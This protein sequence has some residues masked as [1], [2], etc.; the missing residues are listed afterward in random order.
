MDILNLVVD[1]KV[2]TQDQA[3]ALVEQEVTEAAD[4]YK[5]DVA[6]ARANIRAS[7]G[8]VTGYLDPKRADQMM[9]LFDTEHPIFGRSHPSA[10][11]ALRIGMKMGAKAA[12]ESK[13]R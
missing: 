2:T 9:D 5:M 3:A 11:E 12:E 7:I 8:Y 13:Q 10:E 6:V 1:G 4:F